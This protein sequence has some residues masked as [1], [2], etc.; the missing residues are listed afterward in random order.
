MEHY[1]GLDFSL[2]DTS[3]L[4][5]SGWQAAFAREMGPDPQFLAEVIRKR[6]S[7]P[8]RKVFETAPLSV[9]FYYA[10]RSEGMP[11]ICIDAR[12][13]KTHP[14]LTFNKIDANDADGLTHLAEVGF[15]PVVRVKASTAC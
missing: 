12:H 15:Y 7:H 5:S 4:G 1:I 13:A 14:D 11:A 6:A 10:L 2:K 9:W 3:A 8:E